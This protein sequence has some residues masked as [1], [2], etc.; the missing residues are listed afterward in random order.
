[1]IY[2]KIDYFDRDLSM[3]SPD[4]A[5]C[6]L[7]AIAFVWVLLIPLYFLPIRL[8][9]KRSMAGGIYQ[10]WPNDRIEANQDGFWRSAGAEGFQRFPESESL[11]RCG[12]R[13]SLATELDIDLSAHSAATSHSRSMSR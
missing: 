13:A 7:K 6:A 3:H 1:M 8:V 5:D 12:D 11:A 10:V 4:P 2:F 9:P